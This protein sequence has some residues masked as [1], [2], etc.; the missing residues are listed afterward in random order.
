VRRRTGVLRSAPHKCTKAEPLCSDAAVICTVHDAPFSRSFHFSEA[1]SVI[2]LRL[3]TRRQVCA[4]CIRGLDLLVLETTMS[5]SLLSAGLK[6]LR[7]PPAGNRPGLDVLRSLAISLVFAYHISG[8]TP[9]AHRYLATSFNRFG[10]TGVD[11][12]FVLSGFLIGGQL[13]K[14]LKANGTV[15]VRRFILRR[16]FRIWPLYYSLTAFLLAERLFLGIKHPGLYLWIDATFLD[17]YFPD[18]HQIDG[19]WSLSLEEQ[20]YLLIPIALMVGAKFVS[21]RSL[22]RLAMFWL[23][24]LP[25]IRHFVLLA[26]SNPAAT[27]SIY[28]PFHTHSDGLAI[29][30]LISWITTWKPEPLRNWRW[31]DPALVAVFFVGF[32]LWDSVSLTFLYSIV[33]LTY[34][35]LTLLLLRVRLPFIFP[36]N[37]LEHVM[38]YH[39]QLF[40][41][42]FHSF[43]YAFVLYGTV[44]LALAF[45]SFC[46]IELPFLKLRDRLLRSRRTP[47]VTAGLSPAVQG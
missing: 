31:V 26:S 47:P 23:F 36:F 40:G 42:G 28:H 32:G 25:I 24:A 8:Y 20:F 18:H 39:I 44:C 29:G 34:G 17:N 16:G 22:F 21:P 15:D 4:R 46:F 35:A 9:N 12:F 11:L 19:G 3:N 5:W 33:A 37:V 2:I 13:W 30:L 10:W 45:V 1:R 38:R 6:D 27:D 43:L 7:T 41:K 14:E